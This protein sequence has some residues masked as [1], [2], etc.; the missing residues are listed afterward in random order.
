MADNNRTVFIQDVA[1]CHREKIVTQFYQLQKR[2]YLLD[3]LSKSSCCAT[4]CNFK[5]SKL[6]FKKT[7]RWKFFDVR[8]ARFA[9][10]IAALIE[11]SRSTA[12]ELG[13]GLL[14]LINRSTHIC[15]C[16][17]GKLVGES[18]S[19]H[20]FSLF[21][22]FISSINFSSFLFCTVGVL[23]SCKHKNIKV[24]SLWVNTIL[25]YRYTSTQSLPFNP[26]KVPGFLC[27][28]YVY[29]CIISTRQTITAAR[30]LE[31]FSA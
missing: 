15:R 3:V 20:F 31:K 25:L 14:Y 18:E 23:N 19:F 9:V 29:P 13:N 30:Y 6:P 1:L 16:N 22:R 4:S 26:I 24:C 27:L 8:Q 17:A 2:I 7:S 10:K 12:A 11:K 28:N 21:Q 5:R